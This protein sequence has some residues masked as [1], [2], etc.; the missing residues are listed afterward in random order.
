M[1]G[2]PQL[3]LSAES[4]GRTALPQIYD[5]DINLHAFLNQLRH[6]SHTLAVETCVP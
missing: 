2:G 3:V 4:M 1:K 6:G 5:L